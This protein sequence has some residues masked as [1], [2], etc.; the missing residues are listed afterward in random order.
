[1]TSTRPKCEACAT[2]IE[3]GE[4]HT[5]FDSCTFHTCCYRAMRR[6]ETFVRPMVVPESVKI[7][8]C[9]LVLVL[10]GLFDK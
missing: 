6:G 4:R 3:V 7:H 1:M 5:L 10:E 9:A 2:T 8:L